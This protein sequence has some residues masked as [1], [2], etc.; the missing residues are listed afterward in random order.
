MQILLRNWL[1]REI[2]DTNKIPEKVIRMCAPL[3]V[4]IFFVI[5][6]FVVIRSRA[7]RWQGIHITALIKLLVL[8]GIK[9]F[10]YNACMQ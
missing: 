9:T 8:D 1:F 4:L 7:N 10:P 6:A 3:L 5:A 2:Y